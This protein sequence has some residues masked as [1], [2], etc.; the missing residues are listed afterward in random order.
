MGTLAYVKSKML[1][2]RL[3]DPNLTL[4][5]LIDI[6]EHYVKYSFSRKVYLFIFL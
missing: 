4:D 2:A 1:K 3:R 5:E 6:M